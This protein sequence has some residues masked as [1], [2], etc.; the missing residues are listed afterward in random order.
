ML[1]P[2]FLVL[3]LLSLCSF[4]NSFVSFWR[5]GGLNCPRPPAVGAPELY[6]EAK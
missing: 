2:W 4:A 3:A 5:Q 6:M 1:H